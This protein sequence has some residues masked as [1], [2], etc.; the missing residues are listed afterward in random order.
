[1]PSQRRLLL[2]LVR[3]FSSWIKDAKGQG[4]SVSEQ[5]SSNLEIMSDIR[6]ASIALLHEV[7][8]LRRENTDLIEENEGLLDQLENEKDEKKGLEQE[9]EELRK[10]IHDDGDDE[11]V[12]G[13]GWKK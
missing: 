4:I 6:L 10:E 11:G 13:E 1:M 2:G 12:D 9:I 3:L 7:E 5:H 8:S